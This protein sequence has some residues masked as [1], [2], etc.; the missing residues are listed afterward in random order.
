MVCGMSQC[1]IC[2]VKDPFQ[3][4]MTANRSVL[5]VNARLMSIRAS[6]RRR[7][8]FVVA[9]IVLYLLFISYWRAIRNQDNRLVSGI[10]R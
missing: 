4:S 3:K 10:D 6:R 7:N 9:L 5:F 8:N 1:A 2:E